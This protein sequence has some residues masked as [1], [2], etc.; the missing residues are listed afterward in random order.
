[1][2]NG[3]TET[4]GIYLLMQD[5]FNRPKGVEET[6]NWPQLCN[7]LT[8]FNVDGS[9]TKAGEGFS[10]AL[11][12][13]AHRTKD[14][15]AG[16]SGYVLDVE[17]ATKMIDGVE[18]EVGPVPHS[19]QDMRARLAASG[20]RAILYTTHSHTPKRP[21]YRVVIPFAEVM[22]VG[23]S[24]T[25][26]EKVVLLI[27]EL[28]LKGMVDTSKLG[29]ESFFFLPR[30][31]EERGENAEA[32]VIEGPWIPEGRFGNLA[33]ARAAEWR[34]AEEKIGATEGRGEPNPL[35]TK[36]VS[37][38]KP[39][40]VVMA[41]LGYERDLYGDKWIAPTSVS[42]SYGVSI[43][44]HPTTGVEKVV[45]HHA[46]DPLSLHSAVWGV[47]AHDV[48]DLVIAAEFG[49]KADHTKSMHKLLEDMPER[50]ASDGKAEEEKRK[51][52]KAIQEA[53]PWES[54]AGL[55]F[56]EKAPMLAAPDY[57]PKVPESALPRKDH[58]EDEG[59]YIVTAT[60][61][62]PMEL[63]IDDWPLITR[64][65]VDIEWIMPGK[66]DHWRACI[67]AF[68]IYK[69][70]M[71]VAESIA[72]Q[73]GVAWAAIEN[74]RRGGVKLGGDGASG[75]EMWR[76]DKD[77]RGDQAVEEAS[78]ALQDEIEW[79]TGVVAKVAEADAAIDLLNKPAYPTFP[80]DTLPPE[81]VDEV[82]R[83]CTRS[84]FDESAFAVMNLQAV[85]VAMG[86][87]AEV[88]VM[89]G[90]NVK[91]VMWVNLLG[92]PSAKKSPIIKTAMQ[93]L[94]DLDRAS[95]QHYKSEEA[96]VRAR[97]QD[98]PKAE[99]ERALKA[100]PRGRRMVTTDATMEKLG[101]IL[102]RDDQGDR[103]I[104]MLKDELAGW[105]GGMDA[106]RDSN[107]SKD[108]AT[109]LEAIDGGYAAIDRINRGEVMVNNFAVSLAGTMQPEVLQKLAA[110]S[111][112][113]SDGLLQRFLFVFVSE[114]DM[115]RLSDVEA[116]HADDG[117]SISAQ[118]RRIANHPSYKRAR[119]TLSL[120]AETVYD[121]VADYLQAA[122]WVPEIDKG[123]GEWLGK[124]PAQLVRLMMVYATLWQAPD[125]QVIGEHAARQAAK[126]LLEYFLPCAIRAFEM[127]S[128]I[129]QD[130]DTKVVALW[131]LK[132]QAKRVNAI[133]TRDMARSGP[134]CLRT[135][136]DV[137]QAKMATFVAAGWIT[138][139]GE[140]SYRCA[141]HPTS[142]TITPG[143]AERFSG[144]LEEALKVQAELLVKLR[145]GEE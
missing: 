91:M 97:S 127:V 133:T 93:P 19:V 107:A 59:T 102:A 72:L 63:P 15:L 70:R 75:V 95:A 82:I 145:G 90:W 73:G 144:E 41:E 139:S 85:A 49:I 44:T 40:R 115:V 34:A 84:K 8:T 108:R 135:T 24:R 121:E 132:Q 46:S 68:R 119:F 125:D 118:V 86:A 31:L 138:V 126:V 29:A 13:G 130:G 66:A 54:K 53:H 52:A 69:V 9:D 11:F 23:D 79:G 99:L 57:T 98:M 38:L 32:H 2:A 92:E 117:W 42:R 88:K 58:P 64:Q 33:A 26:R 56:H 89:D 6:Y 104:L 114:T 110:K 14:R 137:V 141:L 136:M 87:D 74:A 112:L 48:V 122:R 43:W 47:K 129:P 83:V 103:G 35:V 128:G 5:N 22:E 1:M 106:Y 60:G 61:E 18:S 101:D 4:A 65:I 3:M 100:I 28:G 94:V 113:K 109:W 36:V 123:F 30:C 67:N 81:F 12:D 39:L 78:A 37:K 17:Q 77:W 76:L 105:I 62:R 55:S 131:L 143:L 10:L 51:R 111:S 27:E 50:F 7:L 45:S 120:E 116:W 71:T 21:R 140:A 16:R 96:T 25:D 80:L 124:A 20:Y 142:F 134:Q